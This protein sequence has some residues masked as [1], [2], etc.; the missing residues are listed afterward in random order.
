MKRTLT[1]IMGLAFWSG[2]LVAQQTTQQDISF[3][4]YRLVR[5]SIP[6]EPM[7]ADWTEFQLK[8]TQD[9]IDATW[10]S[11]NVDPE[12]IPVSGTVGTA[13]KG[14]SIGF[15][16]PFCGT[17]MKY[18]GLG[19][20]GL[21]WLSE[22]EDLEA[23]WILTPSSQMSNAIY[24]MPR[25][26]RFNGS[27]QQRATV[28]SDN[29]TK[30]SYHSDASALRFRFENILVS[31]GDSTYRWSYDIVLDNAGNISV[32]YWSVELPSPVN[33]YLIIK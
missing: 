33:K 29:Q 14:I 18:F 4:V 11:T 16:F 3:D 9:S 25:R 32:D 23:L 20:D 8:E 7:P 31:N 24:A 19:G 2:G 26:V 17:D 27:Q 22:T 1:L 5:E 10:L 6:D 13:K 15:D 28:I 21:I 12:S 30:I